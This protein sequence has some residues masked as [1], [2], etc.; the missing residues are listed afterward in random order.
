MLFILLHIKVIYELFDISA[1][2]CSLVNMLNKLYSKKG[3]LNIQAGIGV[4]VGHDLI[5]KAGK[6]G[7]GIN[8][9]IWIGDA[10]VDACNIANK[11]GRNGNKR[12]GFNSLAYNNFIEELQTKHEGTNVK[13]WFTYDYYTK[14]YYASLC[15]PHM[16]EWVEENI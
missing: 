9:R 6:K 4:A 1:Q 12:V 5:I 11:A 15:W 14:T 3:Y 10:V 8:D 2:L 16:D 13:E 7:T